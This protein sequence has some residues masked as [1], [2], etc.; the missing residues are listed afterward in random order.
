MR[1]AMTATL[2]ATALQAF[3]VRSSVDVM[4]RSHFLIAAMYVPLCCLSQR[5]KLTHL[6]I[7]C[8]HTSSISAPITARM[9]AAQPTARPVP[10]FR[11][12][13]PCSSTA[14]SS[15]SESPSVKARNLLGP[16]LLALSWSTP[17]SWLM[18]PMDLLPIPPRDLPRHLPLIHCLFLR[19]EDMAFL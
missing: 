1:Q 6:P 2:K 7:A 16:S 3:G 13:Q 14:T 10:L 5:H 9:S 17:L 18:P 11:R 4:P 8:R 19:R 12:P 15:H